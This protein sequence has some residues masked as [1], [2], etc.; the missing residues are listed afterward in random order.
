[1]SARRQRW[2]SLSLNCLL[3]GGFGFNF[4]SVPVESH[5]ATLKLL[6][7]ACF[8]CNDFLGSHRRT[9]DLQNR[10]LIIAWVPAFQANIPTMS[11]ASICEPAAMK[12]IGPGRRSNVL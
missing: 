12:A 11:V 1:M 3:G 9:S 4:L 10:D 7:P 8:H 6:L 5:L 2:S